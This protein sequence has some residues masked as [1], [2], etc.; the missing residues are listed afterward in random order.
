MQGKAAII[1]QLFSCVL[2]STFSYNESSI[3][4]HPQKK[5]VDLK[6]RINSNSRVCFIT[7]NSAKKLKI[8]RKWLKKSVDLFTKLSKMKKRRE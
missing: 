1:W 6:T 4:Q 8:Q 3:S 7:L 5:S 2:I